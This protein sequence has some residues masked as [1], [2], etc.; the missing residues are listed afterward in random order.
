MVSKE[1]TSWLAANADDTRRPMLKFFMEDVRYLHIIG[2]DV[3]AFLLQAA[4][5][6][7]WEPHKA[8]YK[9]FTRDHSK[10]L[11]AL[12]DAHTVAFPDI[13]PSPWQADSRFG[14]SRRSLAQKELRIKKVKAELRLHIGSARTW[15]LRPELWFD[16]K[17]VSNRSRDFT[18]EELGAN[19]YATSCPQLRSAR[20]ELAA[21]G[22]GRWIDD[23]VFSDYYK[24]FECDPDFNN[25]I[26]TFAVYDKYSPGRVCFRFVH[27]ISFTEL[28]A[29]CKDDYR[30]DS[31]KSTWL[32]GRAVVRP[33][34]KRP[35]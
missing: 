20:G 10:W 9:C 25:A 18:E 13:E 8:L 11:P 34:C 30:F 21:D 26:S 4:R 31:L 35:R 22:S 3:G 24:A 1:L 28:V 16:L 12:K 15:S 33:I 19:N 5:D 29:R 7:D 6:G 27:C 17:Q 14:T 23:A 32:E 2:T